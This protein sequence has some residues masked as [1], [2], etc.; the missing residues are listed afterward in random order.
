MKIYEIDINELLKDETLGL[1]A[2]SIVD[3]PAVESNFMLFSKE[4]EIKLQAIDEEKREIF[5][6]A[7]RADF[8]ILRYDPESG[9]YYYIKFTAEAIKAL[10]EKYLKERKQ[11]EVNLQHNQAWPVERIVM[12]ESIIKDSANGISPKGFE[13]IADGSW[14]VRF[15]VNDE[16]IW[17][18]IKNKDVFNGYSVEMYAELQPTDEE[19]T[20]EE[21]EQAYRHLFSGVSIASLRNAMKSNKQCAI[22][23]EDGHT[24]IMQ[25]Y[26]TSDDTAVAYN[27]GKDIWQE[28]NKADVKAV[29]ILNNSPIVAWINIYD[30]PGYDEVI[31]STDAIRNTVI[32]NTNDINE[33][34]SHN[35]RVMIRYNDDKNNDG[36]QSRQCVIGSYGET[37]RGNVAIR[38]YQ[39]YG[40]SHS[41]S[42]GQGIWRLLLVKRI[43]DLRVLTYMEPETVAPPEFN[44]VGDEGMRVVYKVANFLYE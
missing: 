35:W 3:E 6:C 40:S 1:S 38:V 4:K 10:V 31:N 21:V 8:P 33:I 14:F 16:A 19:I 26:A 7:L 25:I 22:T 2:I 28:V 24:E 32:V 15:K 44:P 18:E 43:Q 34:M 23:F 20:D 29:K 11:N 39:Y 41:S 27:N 36:L 42:S 17:E 13:N 12:T 9:E 30:R 5:G 37:K